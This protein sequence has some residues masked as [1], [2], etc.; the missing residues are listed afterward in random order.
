[1]IDRNAA[2]CVCVA[3]LGLAAPGCSTRIDIDGERPQADP[4]TAAEARREGIIAREPWAFGGDSGEILRTEHY[5]LY[6]TVGDQRERERAALFLENAIDHYTSG[7]TDLPNPPVKLDTYLMSNRVEWEQLT[8]RLMGE[9]GKDI[10]RIQRGGYAARGIGVYFNIGIYDTLAI[11]AHEGWHQYTQRTFR[12]PLPVWL[13]EGIAT[14]MEGHRWNGG[15]VVFTPWGNPERFTTLRDAYNA[16][17]LFTL[18]EL[19]SSRPQDHMSGGDEEPLLRY[20]A[21]V[22]ALTHFLMEGEGARHRATLES[23][24]RDAVEGTLGDRLEAGA[25]ERAS[26]AAM[27][28]RG[29][30]IVFSALFDSDLE[31]ADRAYQEFISALVAVGSRDDI[32]SGRS[33]I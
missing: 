10:M 12:N 26:R 24:L 2:I 4:I 8:L 15:S 30:P 22:W 14:Y 13:E 23:V 31:R 17:R 21:Q 29:G 9:Q 11:A 19:L 6:T 1:M 18:E 25:G 28:S 7:I 5:R 33:P 20:Y 16:G 3:A 32:A 27:S